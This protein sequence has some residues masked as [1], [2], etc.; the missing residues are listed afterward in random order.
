MNNG[1]ARDG[2]FRPRNHRRVVSLFTV[3]SV[4][5]CSPVPQSSKPLRSVGPGT[6]HGKM[7]KS[8]SLAAKQLEAE[9]MAVTAVASR[10]LVSMPKNPKLGLNNKKACNNNKKTYRINNK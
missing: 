5:A 2:D 3:T 1:K 4:W 8:P 7:Q 10:S 9:A 6:V